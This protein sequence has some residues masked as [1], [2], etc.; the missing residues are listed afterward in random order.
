MWRSSSVVARIPWSHTQGK[1]SNFCVL[2]NPGHT[3]LNK[4]ISQMF[5]RGVGEGD[6]LITEGPRC[7]IENV[8]GQSVFHIVY[9]IYICNKTSFQ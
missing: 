5:L 2:V 4:K 6:T 9:I 3:N 7:F 1:I 8:N